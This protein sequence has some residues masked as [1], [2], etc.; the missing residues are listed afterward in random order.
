MKL[1]TWL[2]TWILI[3]VMGVL[4]AYAWLLL[5]PA[6]AASKPGEYPGRVYEADILR[7][8]DGDTVVTDLNVGLGI[9]LHNQH[10]RLNRVDTPERGQPDYETATRLSR[11]LCPAGLVSYVTITKRD[12]YGRWLAEMECRGVSVNDRLLQRGWVYE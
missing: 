7:W 6:K 12:K 4:T 8:V 5:A 10:L 9:W 1:K 3:G 11:S 2:V